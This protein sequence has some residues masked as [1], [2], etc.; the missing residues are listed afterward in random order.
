[1]AMARVERAGRPPAGPAP[2]VRLP[3]FQRVRLSNGLTVLVVRHGHL[4]E[5]SARFVFPYGAAE[6]P[7]ARSGTA[8]MVAR[9]LTE[10]TEERSAREVAEALDFLGSRFRIEVSHDAS[11]L[12]A[13]FLS[14]VRDDA[15]ELLAEIVTRPAFD[16]AEV[17]RLRGERLDE[18]TSSLDEPRNIADLRMNEVS[19]GDHPYAMRTGGVEETVQEIEQSDLRD[20]HTRYYRPAEATL[21]LVGDVP[22][23]D[24]LRDQLEAAFEGWE[25]EPAERRSSA[26]PELAE[27]RSIW[28]VDWPGPQSEI[29]VGHVGISRRDPD[30][31]AVMVVNA[32][33]GGLFSSRVNMN[34]REDKGWTYGVQSRFDGRRDPGPFQITTAVDATATAGAVREILGEMERMK[35]DPPSDE[36][37]ELAR[38][39][40]TLSMPRIFEMIGQVSTRVAHQTLY[41][42]PDDYWETYP[43]AVRAV[44]RESARR[45]AE[46]R[47]APERAGVV[48]VG[49]V[50]AFRAELE[51]VGPVELRDL[52]GRPVEQRSS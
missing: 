37:L 45:A 11:I 31:P 27:R 47:L 33:L 6:D 1:M 35:S 19:F 2:K 32:V 34:L 38:N 4:P 48:V 17:E 39:A 13:Y 49:P 23:G 18:I 41:G 25:G 42:L 21:V 28:A 7:A 12:S 51:T 14:R 22:G 43:D 29:R 16:A 36:E 5:V 46:T 40:L 20:F 44:T 15:F 30:Y 8:L 26:D 24:Q 10:G 9:A 50:D 3:R 52:H